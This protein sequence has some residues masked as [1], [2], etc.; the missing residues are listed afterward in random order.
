MKYCPS[1]GREFLDTFNSCQHDGTSL[2]EE[3]WQDVVAKSLAAESA[4]SVHGLNVSPLQPPI[5]ND[6]FPNLPPYELKP[7]AKTSR[8]MVLVVIIPLCVMIGLATYGLLRST[9]ESKLE[10]AIAKGNLFSPPGANAYDLYHQLKLEGASVTTLKKFEDKLFPL[11]TSQPQHLLA[12]FY[13]VGQKEPAISEW[14]DAAKQL[15]WANELRPD[16]TKTGAKASYCLGRVAY[17][18]G[19]K[20][21]ALEAWKRAAD[22]DKSWAVPTNSVGLIYNERKDYSNARLY[23][24]D[25]VRRDP[26]WPVPYNNLGTSY[27]YQRDYERAIFYYKQC[28]AKDS[29]WARPHAW[30]GTIAMRRE[31]YDVAVQE[32]ERVID[33]VATGTE[34]LDL[35]KIRKELERARELSMPDSADP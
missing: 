32:F 4:D 9:S 23:L 17:L 8:W 11:L 12:G 20:D 18:Q 5:Q 29:R 26:D 27:F 10:K 31:E 15:S 2:I 16:D 1:C 35:S 34:T 14:Q 21:E 19:R 25:A 33:P 30:L 6:P 13:S 7:V 22:L 28:T 3:S 24:L